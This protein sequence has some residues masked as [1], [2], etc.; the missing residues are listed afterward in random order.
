MFYCP[1]CHQSVFS[2]NGSCREHG[3]SEGD[4]RPNLDENAGSG[5]ATPRFA[6]LADLDE[7]RFSWRWQRKYSVICGL[8]LAFFVG[9]ELGIV[10]AG[11][12]H[13]NL[14]SKTEIQFSGEGRTQTENQISVNHRSGTK[15]T[16]WTTDG[17][18]YGVGL[19]LRSD[20]LGTGDLRT[21][22]QGKLGNHPS[23]TATVKEFT[24]S[25]PYWL[26]VYKSGSCRYRVQVQF[27]G[28]DLLNYSGELTGVTDFSLVGLS[29]VR[30]LKQKLAEE[31]AKE[32]VK[33]VE[34]MART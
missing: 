26:P 12:A 15:T 31:I 10:D 18:F 13:F 8:I 17:S 16:T 6:S 11:W 28:K 30:E 21:A 29:S 34:G 3:E 20:H 19:W 1:H 24:L 23:V 27:V 5:P 2:A 22:L 14:G 9:R 33:T 4:A 7:P 25:G 32:V